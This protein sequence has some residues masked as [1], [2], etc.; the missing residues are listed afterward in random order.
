MI[1]PPA[2]AFDDFAGAGIDVAAVRRT[3]GLD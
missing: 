2:K 3:L 1:T